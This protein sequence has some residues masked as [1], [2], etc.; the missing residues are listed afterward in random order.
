MREKGRLG[1]GFVRYL[2]T[3]PPV[4]TLV[5]FFLVRSL[6]L[7]FHP[8]ETWSALQS[9]V[10]HEHA[11]VFR[12]TPGELS[13]NDYVS[14]TVS[15][16]PER[17]VVSSPGLAS[18]IRDK[19]LGLRSHRL[20]RVDRFWRIGKEGTKLGNMERAELIWN[21]RLVPPPVEMH[22]KAITC[23]GFQLA[24]CI[25]PRHRFL[26]RNPHLTPESHERVEA[27]SWVHTSWFQASLTTFAISS[28]V[29]PI[30]EIG[31][32]TYTTK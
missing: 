29:D 11:T 30:G 20:T 25:P 17:A 28:Y 24:T 27:I 3:K 12:I 31:S 13:R 14:D 18:Y 8:F 7:T 4:A 6:H 23:Q 2:L 21:Q 19:T 5:I 9:N 32:C 16:T 1:I 22:C 26:L 15:S 10:S